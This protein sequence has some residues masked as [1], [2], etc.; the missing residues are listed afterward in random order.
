MICWENKGC[1]G[2]ALSPF[3]SPSLTSSSSEIAEYMLESGC[4][5]LYRH[6]NFFSHTSKKLKHAHIQQFVPYKNDE[7]AS[8]RFLTNYKLMVD[9]ISF[10]EGKP[11]VRKLSL[12]MLT[13]FMPCDWS[14]LFVVAECVAVFVLIIHHECMHT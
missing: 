6:Y 4:Y 5:V 9:F 11:E 13:V 14:S 2:I 10:E 8:K 1:L 12:D 3:F 7:E